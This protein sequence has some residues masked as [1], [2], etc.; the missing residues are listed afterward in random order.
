MMGDEL[1]SWR[2]CIGLFVIPSVRI[3]TPP[4]SLSCNHGTRGLSF[5]CSPWLILLF[6]LVLSVVAVDGVFASQSISSTTSAD[7]ATNISIPI[8]PQQQ[9]LISG[10]VEPNPGPTDFTD[11]QLKALK[12]GEELRDPPEVLL[13]KHIL[14]LHELKKTSTDLTWNNA[15][16]WL[17]QCLNVQVTDLPSEKAIR[18]QWETMNQKRRDLLKRVKRSPELLKTWEDTHYILPQPK[19]LGPR[20]TATTSKTDL[21][22]LQSANE[23]LVRELDA[24]VSPHKVSVIAR[25]EKRQKKTIESQKDTIKDLEKKLHTQVYKL[26]KAKTLKRK[27]SMEKDS[28]TKKVAKS[29]QDRVSTAKDHEETISTLENEVA[30]QRET[31]LDLKEENAELHQKLKENTN[32]IVLTTS[33]DGSRYYTAE[34]RACVY[35]LLSAHVSFESVPKVIEAVLE[36][37]G[38]TADNLPTGR[39]VAHMN[40]ERLLLSQRQMEELQKE[41]NLT[42]ATDETPKGG[43]VFM[44]YTVS[45]AESSFVLG[46]REMV[47]KSAEDTLNTFKTILDD[48]SYV[49]STSSRLGMQILTQIKNTMSDR[50]ATE[51]K[52]NDLLKAYREECLPK[53]VENW[54]DFTDA[55]KEKVIHMN[56]FFCGLHLLVSMAE[57]IS[58]SFKGFENMFLEGKKVGADAA[59]GVSVFGSD[60]GTV[61]LVRNTCKALAKGGDEKSGCFRAWRT[62]MMEKGLTTR[63]LQN[64]R[65]N[66]FNIVFLLG[67]HVFYLHNHIYDFLHNVV[68][69]SN[70]LLKA[71]HAD[72]QV[73]LYLAGCKVLG[74]LNKMITAPLWRVTEAPG[75][76]LDMCTTYSKMNKF[77]QEIID[78][79]EKL[80]DFI[81]CQISCFDENFITQDEI[82]NTLSSAWPNDNITLSMMR[83]TVLALQQLVSRVT[84]DYMPGGKYHDIRKSKSFRADTA[85]AP[86]HNKLPERIFGYLDFLIKKRPSA[87]AIANE[88]Q[89]MFVFN[90]TSDFIS[91]LNQEQMTDM[92]KSVIGKPTKEL[93]KTAKQREQMR[94]EALL[95]KQQEKQNQLE[96]SRKSKLKRKEDLTNLIIDAGLWQSRQQVEDK[97]IQCESDNERFHACRNQIRFRREV[98]H[99]YLPE[100]KKFKFSEKGVQKSWTA[101]RDHLLKFIEAAL[102]VAE[103]DSAQSTILDDE[104]INIPLLVGKIVNHFFIADGQRIPYTGKV[105]S[106][107]PGFPQW[108]NITYDDDDAVYTYKLI[109]DYKDGNLEIVP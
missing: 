80:G 58:E 37:A 63:Y 59:S 69:Q 31:I 94:H 3:P 97:M 96:R 102:S 81:G 55:A 83:H 40:D 79:N 4:K 50:A 66:R 41:K 91:S 32:R 87:S 51:A 45:G 39:T 85:S 24:K 6:G 65:G 46:L 72:V 78:S 28:L 101:M 15:V 75:H 60:S 90:K 27:L 92:I 106:Q 62:Y 8:N 13:N 22:A 16:L 52:F 36:L 33:K 17:A 12:S 53:V 38:K 98:L 109:E 89:V 34:T 2:Q 100:D 1:Q 21:E 14:Q 26:D 61:R 95:K 84:K 49:C 67:G 68:G 107:V 54:E 70:G 18:K 23:S 42:I 93:R 7:I 11:E 76:I 5:H 43:D 77:F 19:P 25:R 9:L 64:F 104:V 48:I 105:V 35:K 88:A 108:F 74:I 44:T 10:D 86:K 29:D 71:V 20:S 47:S 73:D 56:N 82:F 99:Q 103:G 57:T 30:V